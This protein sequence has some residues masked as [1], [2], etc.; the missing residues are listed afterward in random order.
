MTVIQSNIKAPALETDRLRLRSHQ[1]DDFEAMLQMWSDPQVVTYIGGK[2]FTRQQVWAKL[3]AYTGLWPL[4]S[5]GY[6]A[7]E[8]KSTGHFI[9]ELGFADFKRE[10]TPSIED[11][12]ELGWA[13]SPHVH[14]K[15]YAT[16]ALLVVLDW[17][18]MHLKSDRTVCIISPENQAS[19]NVAQ[20]IGFCEVTRTTY[21]GSP[22]ILFSKNI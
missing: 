14:G 1:P 19:L 6:W 8:E 15:G 21:N 4:L 5:F 20:K 12:P 11:L 10:M 18:K 17:G 3:I 13:L 16:E 7:V 2:P 22:T 9:G